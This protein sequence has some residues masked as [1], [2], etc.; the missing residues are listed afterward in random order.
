MIYCLIFLI[1]AIVF[2]LMNIIK[3]SFLWI[4]LTMLCLTISACAF[5]FNLDKKEPVVVEFL[6]E[7]ENYYVQSR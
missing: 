6:I 2:L 3:G 4:N 1:L 5:V 7:E